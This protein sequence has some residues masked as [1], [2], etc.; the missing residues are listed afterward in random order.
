MKQ[1]AVAIDGL[2][3][4]EEMT[5][6]VP[7]EMVELMRRASRAFVLIGEIPTHLRPALDWY[8]GGKHIHAELE[9]NGYTWTL[10][11]ADTGKL[12]GWLYGTTGSHEVR[13]ADDFGKWHPAPSGPPWSIPDRMARLAGFHCW[14][15]ARE[16]WRG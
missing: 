7:A 12:M 8:A 6:L 14:A 15:C 16:W 13:V 3:T 5:E 2:P 9:A 11:N 4:L 1:A 10:T